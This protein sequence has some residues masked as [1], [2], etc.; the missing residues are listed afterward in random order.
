MALLNRQNNRRI[1]LGVSFG[2]ITR[3]VQGQENPD[4][5][6]DIEGHLS[7]IV[8]RS[9]EVKGVQTPFLDFIIEDGEDVY[10]LSVQKNSGVARSIILSLASVPDFV[11]N[12]TRIS[13]Y[14]SKDGE[15]T[16]I[17]VYVNKQKVSWVVEPSKIP[18]LKKVVV[19][20]KEYADDT[21]RSKFFDELLAV[22][23]QRLDSASATPQAAAANAHEVGDIP[24]DGDFFRDSPE[25]L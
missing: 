11:N 4:T 16:N 6:T 5:F 2:K 8:E 21:D 13:P 25:H 17:S 23:K 14:L 3:K 9:A 22:I 12:I 1:F 15:H 10:N 18:P 19:G 7:E 24:A 20:S